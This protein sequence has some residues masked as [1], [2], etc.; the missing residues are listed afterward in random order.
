MTEEKSRIT[1]LGTVR[2]FLKCGTCSETMCN[3]L[4]RAFEH[5]LKLEERASAPFA[6]GV[7]RHGYQCG[8]IWGATLAA[9]AEAFR[10]FGPCPKAEA[11]A[12]V[13]AQGIVE[14]FR[15]QN[16]SI[17]CLEI[18]D[19]DKSSS[20]KQLIMYFLAKGGAIGCFRM[21]ARYAPVAFR[22]I[23]AA[24]AD[25]NFDAPSAPVSCAAVLAEKMGVPEQQVVMAAGF[26]GGIGLSGG[27]CGALGAVIWILGMDGMKESGGKVDFEN[28]K[29]QA[30]I[31]K[32][33]KNTDYK[34]DCSEIVGR[35][36][37]NV[38]DHSEYL[39]GG[40]CSLLIEALASE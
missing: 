33:L 40:G 3:V 14:S 6:G 32:F 35:K 11:G 25:G 2:T 19:L 28:P 12:I 10:Q 34:F 27:A 7:L 24:F 36:F 29:A 13:A 16:R 8:L 37:E 5:P 15:T 39:C 20:N 17:N 26:A 21:A 9:G 22:E 4:D 1:S 23:N 31:E 38:A 30:T 18:T